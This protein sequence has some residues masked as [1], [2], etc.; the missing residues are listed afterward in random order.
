MREGMSEEEYQKW[1]EAVIQRTLA[2]KT[3]RDI[4]DTPSE[5]IANLHYPATL[6]DRLSEEDRNLLAEMKIGV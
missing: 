4:Q 5:R 1:V 6:E 2:R 3:C